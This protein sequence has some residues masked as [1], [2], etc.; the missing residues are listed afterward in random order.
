MRSIAAVLSVALFALNAEAAFLHVHKG[1]PA[2]HHH[3]GPAAHQHR[4]TVPESSSSAALSEPDEDSTAVPAVIAK[5]TAQHGHELLSATITV[6]TVHDAVSSYVPHSTFVSR[7]HG[8]PDSRPCSLRAP[9]V[10]SSL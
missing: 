8:P 5:A 7:A 9:P 10:F 1:E 6:A 2:E 3:H 4:I